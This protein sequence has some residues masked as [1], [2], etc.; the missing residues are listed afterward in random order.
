MD[1]VSDGIGL[2][3][4]TR[5]VERLGQ[6]GM[7]VTLHSFERQGPSQQ[8]ANRLLAAGVRWRPH[9]WGSVGATGGLMRVARGARMVVGAELLHARSDLAAAAALAGCRGAW[10]W[11]V[12]AF[13]REQRMAAGALAAGSPQERLLRGVEGAAARS[14]AGVVTLSQA[15]VDI[16]GARYGDHLAAKSRVITTCVDLDAFSPSPLPPPPV[17]VLLA[18]TLNTLYDVPLMLRLMTR[19][20]AHRPAE[21]T[22]LSAGATS[23]PAAFSDAGVRPRAVASGAMPGQVTAHHVGL[24][25]LRDVGVSNAAATPTKLGE[26]LACG[27]PV[28]VNRGLG[29]MD[30]LLTEHDCGVIVGG[31]S[32]QDLD[33]AAVEVIRLIDD[34]AAPGRCRAL[35]EE[36]FNLERGIDTLLEL[37]RACVSDGVVKSA[38]APSRPS[39]RR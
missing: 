33:R 20:R 30:Q 22:V 36:H 16:L 32:D 26:F 15:A 38:A 23:W 3:Q 19:L 11:D 18:G 2:S 13:W 8:V 31:S 5:Y 25:V 7:A 10:V 14:C 17:R 21:L 39:R 35:A 34:P 1:A 4:V 24:S 37:Y 27:R 12:R 6:R 29:D 9:R 28:V